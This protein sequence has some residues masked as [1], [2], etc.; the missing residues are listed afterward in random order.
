MDRGIELSLNFIVILI[1]SLVMFG[2]GVTFVYNLAAGTESIKSMTLEQLD[3]SIVDLRCRY[4]EKVCL[5]RDRIELR[6]GELRVLTLRVLNIDS[7]DAEFRITVRKGIFVSP[8]NQRFAPGEPGWENTILV[9]P[10]ER[11]ERIVANDAKTVGV[12]FERP[13]G[14]VQRGTYVFD[15]VIEKKDTTGL[16]VEY[17]PVHKF[18]VN[19][20]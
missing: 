17:D 13:K 20:K 11:F 15:I 16:F 2:F 7:A 8:D 9:L 5:D 6:Q 12:G 18:Y 10:E 4:N 19:A 14:G 1:I 3:D